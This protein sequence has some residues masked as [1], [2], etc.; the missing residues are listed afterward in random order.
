MPLTAV[1]VDPRK[2]ASLFQN[3]TYFLVDE[4]G[5]EEK[6]ITCKD[7]FL[8]NFNVVP[9][10]ELQKFMGEV[11]LEF[12]N[13]T[14]TKYQSGMIYLIHKSDNNFG[15]FVDFYITKKPQKKSPLFIQKNQKDLVEIL[16]IDPQP[17]KI[18]EIQDFFKYMND[19]EDHMYI[20]ILTIRINFGIQ[21]I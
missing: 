20:C 11:P 2:N 21:L 14:T 8:A 16:F 9:K 3:M 13:K 19:F 12:F 17:K 4:N 5:V 7:N 10:N 18:M 6:K 1:L 15:H